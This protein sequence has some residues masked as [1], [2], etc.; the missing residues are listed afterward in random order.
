MSLV[1]ALRNS[2]ISCC[3]VLVPAAAYSMAELNQDE[4]ASVTG[5]GIAIGFEDIRLQ[6]SPTTR[7]EAIGAPPTDPRFQ[8]AD[9]RWYGFTLS[10]N[11]PV[12]SWAGPCGPGIAGLGCPIGGTIDYL[13]P[14][15]NPYI[16]R[17]F[18]YQGLN[19]NGDTTTQTVLELLG[20]SEHDPYRYSAW[21]EFVVG[22]SDV[23][24]GQAILDDGELFRTDRFGTRQNSEIR[25]LSH[26]DPNDPTIAFV[27]H[28]NW[29]GDFRYSL[30]QGF[31]S[32]DIEGFPP[33]FTDV[34][35]FYTLNIEVYMPLGQLFYQSLI[36]D[37]VASAPGNFRLELTRINE[38]ASSVISDFY[39]TAD[40]SGY[41]RRTTAG[42][43]ARPAR[44]Y[45]THGL[46]RMGDWT[47]PTTCSAGGAGAFN[48]I[49][50]MAGTKNGPYATDDGMF[51]VSRD[52]SSTS[53]RFS[54]YSDR[55]APPT[56]STLTNYNAGDGPF[57]GD[58]NFFETNSNNGLTNTVNLGDGRI[59]GMLIQHLELRTRGVN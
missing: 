56:G 43:D 38:Q 1:S 33:L 46:F 32:Q 40:A 34:E 20:P 35:G 36:L 22:G 54:V 4:M 50:P 3:L 57:R 11:S 26:S 52:L 42:A 48:C 31:A 8:R 58:N 12:S 47:P 41:Q 21:V 25:I 9:A 24:Q 19:F 14:F 45:E 17:A 6:T 23:L 18:D 44:Y 39:S 2:L 13:A 5:E 59:E 37:D 53:A 51:F 29:K 55:V 16:L 15:D 28:N 10:S 49:P 30:N 27:W 7:F